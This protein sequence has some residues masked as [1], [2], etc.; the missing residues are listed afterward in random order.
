MT[1]ESHIRKVCKIGHGGD[2]CKFLTVGTSGFECAKNHPAV[3]SHII[4]YWDIANPPHVAQ[5]D[6]CEGVPDAS[7]NDKKD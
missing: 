6:N 5:G 1:E 7:L 4:M 2:C 3:A